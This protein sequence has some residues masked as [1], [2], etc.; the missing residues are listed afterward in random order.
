MTSFAVHLH[1]LPRYAT[2]RRWNGQDFHDPH[3]GRAPGPEQR[4]LDPDDLARLATEIRSRL[5]R[6]H[7]H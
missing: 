5:M 1:V 3:W 2:S 6:H 7:Q 4:L